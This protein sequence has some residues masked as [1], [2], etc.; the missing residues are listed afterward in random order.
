M[1]MGSGL[2]LAPSNPLAAAGSTGG[3]PRGSDSIFLSPGLFQGVLPQIPNLEVGYLYSSGESGGGGRLTLDYFVPI[4]LG[5]NGAAFGEAHGEFTDFWKTLSKLW[6]D[7]F[8]TSFTITNTTFAGQGSHNER[9]DLSFGVGY[10]RIL[11]ESLL[12]GL[13]GFYDTTNLGNQWYRS[14]C[15]GFEMVALLPG[16]DAIDLNFNYYGDIFRG[17]NGVIDAIGNGAGDFD[18]E[19]GYSHELFDGGPDLRLKVTG[20]QLNVGTKIYGWNAGAEV[21]TRN[22]VFR[23]KADTGKD[24]I[25]GRYYSVGGFVNVGLQP[26]RLLSGE[27]PFVMPEPLFRSPRNM[28]RYL[29]A[30]GPSGGARRRFSQPI[31]VVV[32]RNVASRFLTGATAT[33]PNPIPPNSTVVRPLSPQVFFT[34]ISTAATLVITCQNAPPAPDGGWIHLRDNTGTNVLSSIQIPAGSTSVTVSPV[35]TNWRGDGMPGN[36]FTQAGAWHPPSNPGPWTPG[37]VTVQWFW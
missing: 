24:L 12:L 35:P 1:G 11:G 30:G 4:R 26:A 13:N 21:S 2:D 23:I 9:V 8:E 32:Q 20:Y 7:E 10:R 3:P 36:R 37:T 17:W 31:A 19:V 27:S 5:A 29:L 18:V 14:G 28:L 33:F 34:T 22:G 16:D 25:N 15:I 6:R